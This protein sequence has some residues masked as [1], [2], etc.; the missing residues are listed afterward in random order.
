[1]DVGRRKGSAILRTVM[2]GVNFER[3]GF[4]G[5]REGVLLLSLVDA[6]WSVDNRVDAAIA[7]PL[8]DIAVCG[9]ARDS[10]MVFEP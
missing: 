9:Y 4:L 6:A 2:R 3:I 7:L 8:N 5:I 10:T 1:M